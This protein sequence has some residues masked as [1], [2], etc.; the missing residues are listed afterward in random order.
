MGLRLRHARRHRLPSHGRRVL[1]PRSPASHPY[2]IAEGSPRDNEISTEWI[3]AKYDFPAR[4]SQPPVKLTWY[5]PPKK[6]D[7]L[8]SWNLEPKHAD[9]GVVFIGEKG[10]LYTNYGEHRLLPADKFKDFK[11][12]APTIASSPGHQ[13]EW[14]NA[15]LKNDPTAVGAPFSY[16]VLFTQAALLGVAAFRANQPLDWD[17]TT[18]HIPN[19]P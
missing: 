19:A 9:E 2:R 8:P 12:P 3:V 4:G 15:C 5:D 14:I 7:A 13:Q 11:P 10:M 18:M 1:G 16:G 17:A 6:P